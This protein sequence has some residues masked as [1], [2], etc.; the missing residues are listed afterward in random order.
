MDEYLSVKCPLNSIVLNKPNVKLKYALDCYTTD[1]KKNIKN[2]S[3]EMYMQHVITE[4]YYK[5][6]DINVIEIIQRIS[7]IK[8]RLTIDILMSIRQWLLMKY[9]FNN[10]EKI[11]KIQKLDI[12]TD[13]KDILIKTLTSSSDTLNKIY[14]LTHKKMQII[15]GNVISIVARILFNDNSK[16]SVSP[17]Y[18]NFY[19]EFKNFFDE[20]YSKLNFDAIDGKNMSRIVSNLEDTIVSNI[21]NNIKMNYEKY[22]RK[23]VKASFK[24]VNQQV[25]D[26]ATHKTTCLN[27]IKKVN[28]NIYNDLINLKID[29]NK[30]IFRSDSNYHKWIIDN[31]SKIS[32]VKLNILDYLQTNPQEFIPYM[33]YMNTVIKSS[34]DK[35]L[36]FFPLQND[37]KL[38][39]TMFDTITLIDLLPFKNKNI[40]ASNIQKYKS[41]IWNIYFNT[42][43][44][45]FKRRKYFFD[46]CISTNTF[47]TSIRLISHKKYSENLIKYKNQKAKKEQIAKLC[48]GKSEKEAI[49]IRA[50]YKKQIEKQQLEYKNKLKEIHQQNKNKIKLLFLDIKNYKKDKHS[51]INKILHPT[52]K[53]NKKSLEHLKKQEYSKIL[54][55]NEYKNL[56]ITTKRALL[57]KYPYLLE[58]PDNSNFITDEIKNSLLNKIIKIQNESFNKLHFEEKVRLLLVSNYLE[59]LSKK[60]N[61]EINENLKINISKENKKYILDR[62]GSNYKKYKKIYILDKVKEYNKQ[63]VLSNYNNFVEF[64]NYTNNKLINHLFNMSLM[65]NFNCYTYYKLLAK[66]NLGYANS[67]LD[68]NNNECLNYVIDQIKIKKDDPLDPPNYELLEKYSVMIPYFNK[69]NYYDTKLLKESLN[70]VYIDPGKNCL[71]TMLGDNGKFLRYTNKQ[72][73]KETK[74]KEYQRKIEL[75]KKKLDITKYEAELSKYESRSCCPY[76]FEQYILKKKEIN[77]IVLPLYMNPKLYKLEWYAYMNRNRS[78]TKL[79]RRIKKTF[80]KDCILIIGDWSCNTQLKNCISTPMMSLKRKLKEHFKIYHI[81]E[82]NTSKLYNKTDEVCDNLHLTV[83]LSKKIYKKQIK[84]EKERSERTK[85][86]FKMPLRYIKR[87]IHTV[88]TFK[89]L[90]DIEGDLPKVYTNP[91]PKLGCIN[92]DINAVLN[93]KKIVENWIIS[94]KRLINYSR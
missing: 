70:K 5:S 33:I 46:Y 71:L 47:Y 59:T 30:I 20:Y 13:K 69:L 23:Y 15:D 21:D 82:Y 36:Q 89:M 56:I 48:I 16:H 83:K 37:G 38:K 90:K 75:I 41:I 7:N 18:Q 8:N 1:L 12:S 55:E 72:R 85:T 61:I 74:R 52:I 79:V 25:L 64:V 88:L 3:I 53:G 94:G 68:Y 58:I 67:V 76:T 77:R 44:D 28:N 50:K 73:L 66:S 29:N 2:T 17:S 34:G 14:P 43:N 63:N 35:Q 81:D 6:N 60:D 27:N 22:V 31:I 54:N 91:N 40:L 11:S 57:N 45:I 24:E 19:D 9:N 51:Y 78:M 86:E 84:R 39:Y 42:E 26:K 32:P 65:T 87:K 62:I 93:M 10:Y 4:K 49:E 80:G 92:R